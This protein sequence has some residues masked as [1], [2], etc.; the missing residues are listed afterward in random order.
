MALAA[1]APGH[2][3]GA[4]APP[5]LLVQLVLAEDPA[6]GQGILR[7]RGHLVERLDRPESL[8]CGQPLDLLPEL[9]AEL[10]VVTGDQ[11]PPVEGEVAGP[12][13]VDGPPHD[14]GHD[15]FAGVDRAVVGVSGEP[16][17][18]RRQ[19]QQRGVAG[20]VR[21]GAGR[22]LGETARAAGRQ[23]RA[24]QAEGENL[25]GVH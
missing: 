2:Q 25:V 6:S 24:G 23:P 9:H 14:V 22:R 17:D 19:S 16:L 1:P 12:E 5:Q 7:G 3:V 18:P 4:D 10:V 8:L 13:R 20:E 15:H 21:R 11:G